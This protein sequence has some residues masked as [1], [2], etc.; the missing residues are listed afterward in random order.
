VNPAADITTWGRPVLCPRCRGA[1]RLSDGTICTA[2]EGTGMD[3]QSSMG[4]QGTSIT[5]V[6]TCLPLGASGSVGWRG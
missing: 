6:R 1:K 3:R 2:C 5:E 4:V